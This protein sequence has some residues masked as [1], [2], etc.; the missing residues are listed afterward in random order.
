MKS[1]NP[2]FSQKEI[3]GKTLKKLSK[4]LKDDSQHAYLKVFVFGF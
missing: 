4:T 1:E 2:L 3:Q